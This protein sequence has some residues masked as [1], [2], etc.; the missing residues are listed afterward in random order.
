MLKITSQCKQIM[1]EWTQ[2]NKMSNEYMNLL[3]HNTD[4]HLLDSA[5]KCKFKLSSSR[6]KALLKQSQQWCHDYPLILGFELN[7]LDH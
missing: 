4:C 3:L 7:L 6:L 2:G 1:I 5:S